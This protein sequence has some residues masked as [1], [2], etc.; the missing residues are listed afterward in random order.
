[1]LKPKYLKLKK[2]QKKNFPANRKSISVTHRQKV[3][4]PNIYRAGR[5]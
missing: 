3:N 4:L 5:N 1:M 2:S